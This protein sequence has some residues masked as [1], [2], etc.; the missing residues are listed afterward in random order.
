MLEKFDMEKSAIAKHALQEDHMIQWANTDV[1]HREE[2]HMKRL[3]LE[4]IEVGKNKNNFNRED[5]FQLS[6]AW[7]TLI[8][9]D[10]S[11]WVTDTGKS[12]GDNKPVLVFPG[13]RS[14]PYLP[15]TAKNSEAY[16]S[17]S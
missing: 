14:R 13:K 5:G 7:K 17:R 15:R 9:Q 12:K 3:I 6:K 2:K 1:L 10:T 11:T 4:A 16:K 8:K